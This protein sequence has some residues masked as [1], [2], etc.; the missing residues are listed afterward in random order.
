MDRVRAD[1]NSDQLHHSLRHIYRSCLKTAGRPD[2]AGTKCPETGPT[3]KLL[4]AN[5]ASIVRE[6]VATRG[7]AAATSR[8][9]FT[10]HCHLR[11]LPHI[12]IVVGLVGCGRN[13]E[14]LPSDFSASPQGQRPQG[15]AVLAATSAR[16]STLSLN[17]YLR[18]IG[19]I[20]AEVKLDSE[21]M[22][23]TGA[24]A[25][26]THKTTY[27]T[28]KN[29]RVECE[30]LR[31]ALSGDAVA[32]EYSVQLW[33][34][35]RPLGQAGRMFELRERHESTFAFSNYI[36]IRQSPLF[37]HLLPQHQV[38]LTPVVRTTPHIVVEFG[39]WLEEPHGHVI[40]ELKND[41]APVAY[42]RPQMPLW[43]VF[44]FVFVDGAELMLQVVDEA[45]TDRKT[46]KARVERASLIR[47]T[48]V[49]RAYARLEAVR[50]PVAPTRYPSAPKQTPTTAPDSAGSGRQDWK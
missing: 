19:H 8:A 26:P 14:P 38:V 5:R 28:T 44:E 16:C 7:R 31:A 3:G 42:V 9:D 32:G 46:P 45:R 41:P 50:P 11:M 21:P 29:K 23:Q 27:Y 48:H 1:R 39:N 24:E 43:I 4:V 33:V 35:V 47:S 10:K 22:R 25:S 12:L 2:L 40:G 17:D 18:E 6:P 37:I 36:V 34:F 20:G 15:A 49:C 13:S 30:I